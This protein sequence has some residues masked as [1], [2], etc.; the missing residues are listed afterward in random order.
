[1]GPLQKAA[2][3]L[4]VA[5]VSRKVCDKH[6]SYSMTKSPAVADA[7]VNRMPGSR[8]SRVARAIRRRDDEGRV[9]VAVTLS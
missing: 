1:M 4:R 2:G 7:R 5:A 9:T 3:P 6:N 8:P